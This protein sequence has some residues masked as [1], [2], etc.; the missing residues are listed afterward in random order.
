MR[1]E[2]PGG[3]Q[4]EGTR[5]RP[6][7]PPVGP[8]AGDAKSAT[9]GRDSGRD[10]T[11]ASLRSTGAGGGARPLGAQ[12]R[13]ATRK[14]PERTAD[15]ARPMARHG[16]RCQ[17]PPAGRP[18]ET[19]TRH[20]PRGGTARKP[21][22]GTMAQADAPPH[23][24]LGSGGPPRGEATPPR[25]REAPPANARPAD[26]QRDTPEHVGGAREGG[27][28]PEPHACARSRG[29]RRSPRAGRGQG[30]RREDTLPTPTWHEAAPRTAR[31]YRRRPQQAPSATAPP[32]KGDTGGGPGPPRAAGR[33]IRRASRR[34]PPAPSEGWPGIPPWRP[35]DRGGR[36]AAGGRPRRQLAGAAAGGRDGSAGPG[37]SGGA[38]R[39][40]SRREGRAQQAGAQGGASP[41][42]APARVPSPRRTDP[43]SGRRD[44]RRNGGRQRRRTGGSVAGRAP[45][46]QGEKAQAPD[47]QS[48]G[49]GG[50][51]PA[52]P[53]RRHHAPLPRETGAPGAGTPPARGAPGPDPGPTRRAATGRP[54]STPDAARA[55]ATAAAAQRESLDAALERGGAQPG[56]GEGPD[57]AGH[58]RENTCLRPPTGGGVP[59]GPGRRPAGAG[60]PEP[61]APR[62]PR[63]GGTARRRGG[64]QTRSVRQQTR[65]GA[66]WGTEARYGG[67]PTAPPARPQAAGEAAGDAA[68][69]RGLGAWAPSGRQPRRPRPSSTKHAE[70]TSPRALAP[71]PLVRVARPPTAGP[72]DRP[73][74]PPARWAPRAR[75]GGTTT[76]ARRVGREATRA[77]GGL[78]RL[79]PT[80][81]GTE[82]S[83]GAPHARGWGAGRRQP[84]QPPKTPTTAGRP[85]AV[86]A[87]RGTRRAPP[88]D[89]PQRPRARDTKGRVGGKR[90]QHRAGGVPVPSRR[91]EAGAGGRGRHV[92]HGTRPPD[93]PGTRPSAA[94]PSRKGGGGE[95][96][97]EIARKVRGGGGQGAAPAAAN[98]RGTARGT[99]S[100]APAGGSNGRE[101]SVSQQEPAA[102][103]A[104]GYETTRG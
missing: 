89:R 32:G 64:A 103:A 76:E 84:A 17:K 102:S 2:R 99:R 22:P 40:G 101:G 48:Q 37:P 92:E 68:G 39:Q 4:R 50:T 61:G 45:R 77:H 82:A 60:G 42:G 34:R 97:G 8:R 15:T 90:A 91:K 71:Q 6:P 81:R 98:R 85:R 12:Q 36:V 24:R 57:G 63:R 93:P 52:G 49:A 10:T 27:R 100:A 72:G 53:T 3:G 13:Q 51:P 65:R 104:E 73:R 9:S 43:G 56:R 96:E 54:A 44:C 87:G 83:G 70:R 33:Q 16:D 25:R 88:G 11:Q 74:P 19:D 21:P 5:A 20:A 1:R 28:N 67:P 79:C 62:S 31:P 26:R 18:P 78:R 46:P 47:R 7:T 23:T 66:E 38:R 35:G 58:P 69:E 14:P 59:R 55:Q 95:T 86:E 75:K 29:R 94:R 80:A 41:G 30:R